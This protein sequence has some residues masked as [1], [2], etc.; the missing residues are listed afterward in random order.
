MY[1]AIFASKEE[2]KPYTLQVWKGFFGFEFGSVF[3]FFWLHE[4]QEESPQHFESVKNYVLKRSKLSLRAKSLISS[5]ST[6]KRTTPCPQSHIFFAFSSQFSC[7]YFGWKQKLRDIMFFLLETDPSSR[8]LRCLSFDKNNF[9]HTQ[10]LSDIYLTGI[11]SV[12]QRTCSLSWK[13][14]QGV[15]SVSLPTVI[16]EKTDHSNRESWTALFRRTSSSSLTLKSFC[17]TSIQ[18]DLLLERV[19]VCYRLIILVWDQWWWCL[20]L[21][22]GHESIHDLHYC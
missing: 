16:C 6:Q 12:M 21:E 8:S 18:F 10:S 17:L 13:A 7:Q 4:N 1:S 2:R 3:L 5:L 11:L 20:L 9:R 22:S 19:C 15:L 14:A